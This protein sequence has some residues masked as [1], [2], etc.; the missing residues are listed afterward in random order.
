[1]QDMNPFFDGYKFP[2]VKVRPW[3][4]VLEN[5]DDLAIDFLKRLI[6]YSPQERFTAIQAMRHPFFDE[7]KNPN[8]RLPDGDILPPLFNWTEK[9]LA[10]PVP[11][12]DIE[13]LS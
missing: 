13:Q 9:E 11:I 6:C 5:A 10:Y 12:K 2:H 4:Q 7:I 1:M 8:A 3:E